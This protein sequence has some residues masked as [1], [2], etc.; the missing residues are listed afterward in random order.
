MGIGGARNIRALVAD[1]RSTVLTSL[2][3]G[4]SATRSLAS[5]PGTPRSRRR[6]FAATLGET[7]STFPNPTV[8]PDAPGTYG[9]L[10][11]H[12]LTTNLNFVKPYSDNSFTATQYFRYSC[13]SAPYANL[14]GPFLIKRHLKKDAQGRWVYV[15]SN[16]GT[17]VTSTYVL[18]NQ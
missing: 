2:V 5:Q 11:D 6:T 15:I 3:L 12:N 9:S 4:Y 10:N 7:S 1:R 17:T 18:P 8:P 13:A 16:T 14:A